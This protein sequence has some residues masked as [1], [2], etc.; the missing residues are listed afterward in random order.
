MRDHLLWPAGA[1]GVGA[2]LLRPP[3]AYCFCPQEAE[4]ERLRELWESRKTPLSCGNR[5]GLNKKFAPERAPG[6][7][8]DIDS[9]RRA[10]ARRRFAF[11]RARA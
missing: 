7:V 4:T 3:E 9:Y 10:I 2:F 8:Y 6:E 5:P 11:P 1:G